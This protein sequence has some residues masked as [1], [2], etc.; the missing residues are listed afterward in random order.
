[1][2]RVEYPVISGFLLIAVLTTATYAINAWKIQKVTESR[3]L[4]AATLEGLQGLLFVIAIVRIIDLTS[5]TTGAIA[6]VVGAFAGT[7]GA[8]LVH[9]KRQRSETCHC[10]SASR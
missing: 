9:R 3:A 5:S 4:Y 6:Y 8:V 7:A 2:D 10:V 1:M